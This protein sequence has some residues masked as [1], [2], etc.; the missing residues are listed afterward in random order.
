MERFLAQARKARDLGADFVDIPDRPRGAA[1]VSALSAAACVVQSGVIDVVPHYS[2]S[3]R[4]AP[5]CVSDLLGASVLGINRVLVV[6][7]D[8][9]EPESSGPAL[10]GVELVQIASDV[11]GLQVGAALAEADST[12][13]EV[14][15]KRTAGASFFMT[16]PLFHPDQALEL[17]WECDL[18]LIVGIGLRGDAAH[19]RQL[20]A[21][22][23]VVVPSESGES[24]VNDA[25]ATAWAV[26]QSGV[27][28][29]VVMPFGQVGAGL[30][31][32]RRLADER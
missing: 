6:A 21:I 1:R 29:V 31:V 20:A 7:G 14:A 26:L 2:A 18:P 23:G 9:A 28:G 19:Q 32:V 3:G 5:V 27:S 24:I 13:P 12:R 25:V 8:A 4:S 30:E 10:S 17:S 22:P 15:A 16:Q 11:G